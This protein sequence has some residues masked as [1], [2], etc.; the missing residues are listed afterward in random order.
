M[1]HHGQEP[2]FEETPEEQDRQAEKLQKMVELRSDLAGVLGDTGQY[3]QGALNEDDE[4]EIKF[5][6]GVKE[7]KVCLDFGKRVRWIG[8]DPVQAAQLAATLLAH[9]GEARLIGFKTEDAE[10]EA[11]A[12]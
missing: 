3:P 8:M 4:G 1:A 6:V 9:A 2:V 5:A 11:L 7:G 10:F 12:K